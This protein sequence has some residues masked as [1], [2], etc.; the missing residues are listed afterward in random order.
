V[1]VAGLRQLQR[2]IRQEVRLLKLLAS[3]A[4][5]RFA[6]FEPPRLFPCLVEQFLRVQVPLQDVEVQRDQRH[7]LVEQRNLLRRE[8]TERC[9]F[10]HRQQRVLRQRGECGGL[11]R[12]RL[13]EG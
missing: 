1:P 5:L 6:R 2:G 8:R 11:H 4:Q 3:L 13:A 7:Q 10:E 9:D 12:H